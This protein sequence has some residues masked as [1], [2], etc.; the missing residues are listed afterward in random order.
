VGSVTVFSVSPPEHTALRAVSWFLIA[1]FAYTYNDI[2]DIEIDRSSHPTRPLPRGTITNFG[3]SV[4]A[5]SLGA[6]GALFSL[7]AFR[8][9]SVLCPAL[10]IAAAYLYSCYVRRLNALFANLWTC[11]TVLLLLL[12]T[13][14]A[15][16]TALAALTDLSLGFILLARELQKD[17]AD[18]YGDAPT[19]PLGYL[20][21]HEAAG[22]IVYLGLLGAALFGF[23]LMGA[24][25][26]PNAP[27]LVALILTNLSILSAAILVLFGADR[28]GA[29][30]LLTKF[31]LYCGTI[32]LLLGGQ[33]LARP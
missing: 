21:N 16:P 26:H 6:G 18:S 28:A 25:G 22:N 33:H 24:V 14:S 32:L 17:V 27:A 19:R 31:A 23:V 30:I 12:S 20:V 7:A 29:Q 11:A 13:Q 15:P 8:D 2:R 3:A 5:A 9:A 1:A 4:F 10:A